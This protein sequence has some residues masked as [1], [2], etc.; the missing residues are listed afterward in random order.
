[1]PIRYSEVVIHTTEE[2]RHGGRPLSQEV[3]DRVHRLHT[4]ARC[5]VSRGIAGCFENGEIVTQRLEVLAH[6]MPLRISIV[7]PTALLP[8]VLPVVDELVSDGI[9]L[10]GEMA[11]H[12]HRVQGRVLPRHLRV[13]DVMT[14]SPT[15]VSPSTPVRECVRLLLSLGLRCLIV[16]DPA[17]RPMGIVTQGD[18]VDRGG[19]PVRL[20]LLAELEEASVS[21]ALG[22]VASEPARAIMSSPV[23]RVQA[24]DLVTEAAAR[25]A[26]TGLKRLP[27]VDKDGRLAGMLSRIDL[28]RVITREAT[29]W[30][31]EEASPVDVTGARFV[32]DV[33][34]REAETVRP[35]ASV[36]S[37]LRTMTEARAQRVAVTD[38]AGRLVGLVSDRDLLPLV[39]APE[40]P[41]AFGRLVALFGRGP[42]RDAVT[43]DQVLARPVSEF[44][45][46]APIRVREEDAL[47]DAI[48][49]MAEHGLKRL[50]VID[51]E[52]VF[53]GMIGREGVLRAG[54]GS[55]DEDAG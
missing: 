21:D 20:G 2:A 9:V 54:V 14:P 53:R 8:K 13:R 11:L 34:E 45:H 31:D 33:M 18:L 37:V 10:I 29:D 32:R 48:R 35:T 47:M 46:A 27:V 28:F 42:G 3:V 41:G 44:L 12:R 15:T 39:L 55:T 22:S 36:E 52:G 26:A 4:N 38:E 30:G 51:S 23:E 17:G 50:P 1:M 40:A 19:L 7:L 25:M 5:I 6:S 24:D 49:K 16:T 43:R